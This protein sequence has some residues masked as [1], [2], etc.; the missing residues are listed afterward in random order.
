M[1][2]LEFRKNLVK[3]V[4][5]TSLK[6]TLRLYKYVKPY[7]P[8]FSLGMLFLFI[9][10]L[11][12]LAF[13]K[14]LGDLVDSSTHGRLMHDMNRLGLMLVAVLACQALFSYFRII[15]FV[16]VTEKT[17]A[18]LRQTIYNHLIKLPMKF[19]VS[20]RVGE[21]GSRIS[22]DISM[23][24]ETFTTT[25]AEFIRQI[26]VIIGGIG[27]L[28]HTSAKLTLFMLAIFPFI[29]LVAYVFGRFIRRFS[30][31]VQNQVAEPKTIV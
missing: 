8:Q 1:Q 17:L 9:S 18:T 3:G 4:S 30:K 28:L 29:M 19:F 24:Q 12:G 22:S 11:A 25:I 14:L 27:L 2:L 10:S 6:K 31:Q 26:I 13:P 16:N 20:R 7:W 23:L 15:L 21:L 5:L